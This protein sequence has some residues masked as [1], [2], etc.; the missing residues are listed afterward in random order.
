MHEFDLT[1][2]QFWVILKFLE[3]LGQEGLSQHKKEMIVNKI[4]N[5]QVMS[6][7]YSK[8]D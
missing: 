1:I 6:Y 7:L 5:I 3:Q 2:Q 4:E 8:K